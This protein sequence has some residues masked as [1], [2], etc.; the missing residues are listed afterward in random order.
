MKIN[1][2]WNVQNKVL[3]LVLL[4]MFTAAIT[5]CTAYISIP[6]GIGFIHIGDGLIFMSVMLLG[7]S[8]AI[9]AAVG[10]ALAD[11]ITSFTIFAPV[12]F[13]VKGLMAILVGLLYRRKSGAVSFLV[14][15][16]LFIVAELLMMVGYFGYECLIW[17][18]TAAIA[19][20]PANAIQGG[21]GI[22]IGAVFTPFVRKIKL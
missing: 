2:F 5:V 19:E 6:T 3:R 11:L 20:V 22:L 18:Y 7:P 16:V 12:S 21:A 10:S 13:V 15:V 17:N 14:N 8:G 1:E 4:A 9:A